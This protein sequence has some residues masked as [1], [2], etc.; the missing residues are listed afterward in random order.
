MIDARMSDMRATIRRNLALISFA[1]LVTMGS[2]R[3]G[4]GRLSLLAVM[5]SPYP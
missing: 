5:R 3:G 4:Y 2:V 1:V